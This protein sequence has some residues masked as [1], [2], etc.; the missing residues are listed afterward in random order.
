MPGFYTR[1]GDE[2]YTDLFGGRAAKYAPRPEA[3][4][5]LDEASAQIG[6]ARA[7]A[8]QERT[9][10][11]LIEVQRDLYLLMAELAF[12]PELEQQRYHITAEQVERVERETDALSD[13][14]PLPPQFILPGDT[15]S[16]AALDVARTV[17]RR[18][19]RRVVKLAHDGDFDNPQALAYLNRLSSLLFILARYED[20]QAG[21][22]PLRAK[23]PNDRI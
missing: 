1:K 20:L 8:G 4:G 13:E 11:I 9:R 7:V 22:T 14:T 15:L 2:G 21:V 19:E 10:L 3:I 16:G 23:K 17:A 6:F 12:T 5:T 18:A